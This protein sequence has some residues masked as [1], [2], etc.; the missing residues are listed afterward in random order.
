MAA[1]L[2]GYRD[3][4]SSIESR[5]RYSDKIKLADGI[6]PYEVKKNE[7]QDDV[8]LWPGISHVHVCMYLILTPSPYTEK[9]ML[10]YKSLDSYQNFTKGWVRQVL[11]KAI[12]NKRIVIGKVCHNIIEL[13][14]LTNSDGCYVF[15][16]Q[17][18]HSQRLNEKPLTPWIVSMTDGKI[19]AA[20]CDCMAGLGETCSHVSSLLW[21]IAVGVE[22]RDS[23]TVTQKSAYWVMPTGIRSVAY[24][25]VK[26]ID[27]IGKKRKARKSDVDNSTRGTN[28]N[29]KKKYSQPSEEEKKQ[30]LNSLASCQT[31]KPAVLSVVRDHCDRYVPCTFDADLLLVLSAL[32]DSSNLDLGYYDLLKL[33]NTTLVTV[34]AEQR[35]AVEIKTRDQSNSRLWFSMRTGRV[36]ASK[37]KSACHTDPASPSLSLVMGICH[38]EAYRFQTAAT[39]WGCRHEKDASIRSREQK[40]MIHCVFLHVVSSLVRHTLILEHHLMEWFTVCV[41]DQESVK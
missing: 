25:P 21:V 38:P 32:Y 4:L 17:V 1:L 41:A 33:S 18:N 9:D 27:F 11:V 28:N 6:D 35:K 40:I 39:S 16:C 15:L 22:K 10:N 34:T 19:L 8:D 14:V 31:A 7:W 20:H 3:S 13:S 24:A 5:K 30:F 37:F 26:D 36:T 29:K 23:L 2:P 12:G